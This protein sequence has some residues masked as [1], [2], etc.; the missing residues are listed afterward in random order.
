M[1]CGTSLAGSARFCAVTT[2]SSSAPAVVDD[3]SAYAPC[4][5]A[6]GPHANRNAAWR[7]NNPERFIVEFSQSVGFVA[8]ANGAEPSIGSDFVGKDAAVIVMVYETRYLYQI[9]LI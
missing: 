8:S 6:T 5:P 7:E 4:Q 9:C 2:I 1:D 3:S